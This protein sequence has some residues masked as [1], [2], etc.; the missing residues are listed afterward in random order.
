MRNPGSFGLRWP[1][2]TRAFPSFDWKLDLP[3]LEQLATGRLGSTFG[4]ATRAGLPGLAETW[5][6][7]RG[8]PVAYDGHA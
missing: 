7:V 6:L 4:D 3:E 2:S 1:V 8:G 5:M